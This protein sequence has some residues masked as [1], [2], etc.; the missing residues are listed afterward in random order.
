MTAALALPSIVTP[1]VRTPSLRPAPRREPP[2]DDELP[3]ALHLVRVG[4]RPLPFPDAPARE[5]ALPRL[6][7]ELPDPAT[8][9]RR[10]VVGLAEAA[11]GR[12]PLHQ[13]ATLVSPSVCRG[14]AV[15][16]DRAARAGTRHWL[17]RAV[18]RSVHVSRPSDHVAELAATLQAGRRVR[19]MALRL[20][21]RHGR[22]CCTRLQMA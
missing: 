16:F 14:L 10:L 17:H 13:V 4:D 15:D 22:W 2:F 1:P 12:R 20:E 6:A 21:A 18:V 11:T 7:H 5:P 19:A 9:V 3:R 8:W